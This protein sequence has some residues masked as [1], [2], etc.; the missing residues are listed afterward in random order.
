MKIWILILS[1]ILYLVQ[2][3]QNA[4]PKR[5]NP[6]KQLL[7]SLIQDAKWELYK[8]NY[9]G[10]F[11]RDDKVPEYYLPYKD[12]IRFAVNCD[13]SPAYLQKR[14]DTIHFFFNYFDDEKE[15]LNS[16]LGEKDKKMS[17]PYHFTSMSGYANCYV[18]EI[19]R[20]HHDYRHIYITIQDLNQD[21]SV[22]ISD[23]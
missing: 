5:V 16:N 23:Y 9:R 2:A 7:D 22:Y 12:T 4:P 10:F 19:V 14:G 8:Y 6:D 18:G 15:H 20:K 17:V 13:L 3:C 21:E 1:S 11:F